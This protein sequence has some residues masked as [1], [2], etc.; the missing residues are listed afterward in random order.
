MAVKALSLQSMSDWKQL[1]LFQREAATLKQLKHPGIPQYVADFEVDT[2][3]DRGYFLVQVMLFPQSPVV[4]SSLA[5]VI[6]F[7]QSPVVW[8]G[9]DNHRKPGRLSREKQRHVSHWLLIGLSSRGWR[10]A[11]AQT[12]VYPSRM[13]LGA[14]AHA[15]PDLFSSP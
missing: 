12:E 15:L 10:H 6:L 9:H 3:R 14:T 11:I 2:D 1:D 13:K 7:P 8:S 5:Q 4:Q